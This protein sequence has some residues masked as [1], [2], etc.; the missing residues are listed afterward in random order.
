MLSVDSVPGEDSLPDLQTP[1]SRCV[2]IWWRENELLPLPLL[3]KVQMALWGP[4]P[5][6]LIL[7]YFQVLSHWELQ[8]QHTDLDGKGT[9]TFSP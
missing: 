7:T 2:L 1:P 5:P 8:I 3:I 9:Q 4:H 6:H